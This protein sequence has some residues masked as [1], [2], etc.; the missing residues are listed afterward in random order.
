M[1]HQD[2]R[3]EDIFLVVEV[4]VMKDQE[5]P[6]QVVQ[7]V[8]ELVIKTLQDQGQLEQLTLVVVEVDQVH[9]MLELL[10]VLV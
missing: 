6:V 4:E 10:V 7:V 3:Q 5:Q 2:Q 9:L 1:E 8:A